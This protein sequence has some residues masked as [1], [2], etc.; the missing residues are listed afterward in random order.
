MDKNLNIIGVADVID[1][2]HDL[3]DVIELDESSTTKP[4]LYFK[5]KL[6]KVL[7]DNGF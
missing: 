7:A 3:I 1:A 4:V 2:A 5:N 6:K